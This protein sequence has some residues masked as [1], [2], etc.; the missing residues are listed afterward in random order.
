[1]SVHFLIAQQV[2]VDLLGTGELDVGLA[3]RGEHPRMR[4]VPRIVVD[5]VLESA[6]PPVDTQQI[7]RSRADEEDR[8]LV[9]SEEGPDLRDAIKP[10]GSEYAGY[11]GNT[12]VLPVD[13][14][15]RGRQFS[16]DGDTGDLE[17]V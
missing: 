7:E 12:E 11:H 6:H 3:F 9:G 1:M 15:G 17:I 4:A 2:I 14:L 16:H 5:D 8:L 13:L 10:P